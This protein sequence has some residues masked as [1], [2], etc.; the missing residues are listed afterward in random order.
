MAD[1]RQHGTVLVVDDN[2]DI[3]ALAKRFLEIAGYTVITAADGEEGLS[4]YEKHRSSIVLLLTDV[5]MP[6][7]NG[8]EL[9]DRVLGMDSKLPVLFMSG[10]GWSAYRELECLAKPFRPDELIETVIRVLYANAQ[11][12]KMA[13]AA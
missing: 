3:R 6:N 13:S 2:V 1:D 4:F 8:L 10:D 11:S 12:R 5:M 9:A 7:I